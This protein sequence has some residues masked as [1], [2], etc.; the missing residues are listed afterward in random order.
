M[1]VTWT[2]GS[3][4]GTKRENIP[5]TKRPTGD[6]GVFDVPLRLTNRTPASRHVLPTGRLH[7]TRGPRRS[8]R[9]RLQHGVLVMIRPQLAVSQTVRTETVNHTVT[10]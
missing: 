8:V 1:Y 3:S 7:C 9:T 5:E 10:V 6:F 2:L 4:I